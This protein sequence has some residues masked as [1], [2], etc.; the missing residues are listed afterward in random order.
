[1]QELHNRNVLI[2]EGSGTAAGWVDRAAN[3][4]YEVSLCPI[5]P[6]QG[7]NLTLIVEEDHPT[8]PMCLSTLPMTASANTT[9]SGSAVR[10]TRLLR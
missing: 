7:L 4:P 5:V 10:M 2:V 8:M 9:A 6:L 1:M 3:E